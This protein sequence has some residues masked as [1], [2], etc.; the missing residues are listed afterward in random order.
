MKIVE[1]QFSL[2]RHIDQI[3]DVLKANS[4]I[5]LIILDPLSAFLGVKDSHRDS[6]VREVLR[7]LSQMAADYGVTVIGI[8]HLN[9]TQSSDPIARFIGST[10]I[11]AS[12]RSAYLVHGDDDEWVFLPV[13]SNLAEP[14]KGLKYRINS[15]ELP[16]GISTSCIEWLGETDKDA[17]EVLAP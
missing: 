1:C 7:P 14:R 12:A 8:V 17:F 5:R 13:K 2:S 10:G 9:K 3:T 6:D 11:I 16:D 4:E 15:V